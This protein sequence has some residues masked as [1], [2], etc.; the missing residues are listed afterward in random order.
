[1]TT[2][3]QERCCIRC[4]YVP[5]ERGADYIPCPSCP[6]HPQNHS[7][8]EGW[9]EGFSQQ[10]HEMTA[11]WDDTQK[12]YVWPERKVK[13]FIS[14]LLAKERESAEAEGRLQAFDILHNM[15]ME[16]T[17]IPALDLIEEAQ[18]RI[19]SARKDTTDP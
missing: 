4:V 9:E 17:G 16:T 2:P 3:N 19:L 13:S 15:A 18:K 14:K 7:T 12:T 8:M 6:C 10:F 5:E 11:T 1:M